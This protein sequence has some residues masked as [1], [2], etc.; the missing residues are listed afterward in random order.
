[1]PNVRA[2]PTLRRRRLGDALRV[3][4]RRAGLSLDRAA[5]LMGWAE[6][7]LSRIEN[8][9]A[10][11]HPQDIAVL[12]A[13]YG[14]T[15]SGTVTALE[16]LAR[17]ASKTGWW[18]PYGD[19][20]AISYRDYLT[21]ESDAGSTHIYTPELIPGLLQTGAYAREVIAATAITRTPEEVTALAEVRKA[22]QTI[23][24]TRDGGPLT[25]WAVI[26]ES[27]FHKRFAATPTIMRDQL[28]HL[29]DMADLPN[30]TIQVMPLAATPHPGMLGTF[31]IVRFPAPWPN[32]VTLESLRGTTFIEGTDD[33]AIFSAAFQRIVAAALSVDDSRQLIKT[34]IEKG[35]WTPW[36]VKTTSTNST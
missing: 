5:E 15:D 11:M 34:I 16:G 4:R 30:I 19:V 29:L 17:D 18:Q 28:R 22:R 2:V 12:L 13:L 31:E 24:T 27:A 10:R 8:A 3:Y 26:H 1:M 35:N 6:S 23:L 25:L 32:V 36:A 20:V 14:V 9:L 21:L 7:K 33:A